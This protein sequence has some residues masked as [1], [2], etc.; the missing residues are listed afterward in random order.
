[1]GATHPGEKTD[2]AGISAAARAA[3]VPEG[4]R[5]AEK[6]SS[7]KKNAV[8][9]CFPSERPMDPTAGVNSSHCGSNCL[10]GMHSVWRV[11]ER[12]TSAN[13]LSERWRRAVRPL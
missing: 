1:M 12:R 10:S 7:L 6:S 4:R 13:D 2:H 11:A 8:D 3:V 9:A 5:A